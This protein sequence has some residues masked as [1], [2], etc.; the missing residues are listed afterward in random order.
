[1]WATYIPSEFYRLIIRIP[2]SSVFFVYKDCVVY[3]PGPDV[4]A[5]RLKLS[6][7]LEFSDR[8]IAFRIGGQSYIDVQVVECE[9]T[10]KKESNGFNTSNQII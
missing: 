7:W 8:G 2:L 5:K 1:M 4:H 6:A 10:V 3:L 9:H